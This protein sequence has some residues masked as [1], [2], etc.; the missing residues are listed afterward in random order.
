V[1]FRGK[2]FQA[3]RKLVDSTARYTLEEGVAM[4]PKVATAKFDE[5]VDLAV[6]LGVDPRQADQMVRGAVSLPHGVGKAVRVVV[7]AE[8]EAAKQAL[9]AGA[10]VVGG[11]ELI[12]KIANERWVDFDKAISVRSL[13]A[14]VGRLGAVLGPRGLMPNP[15]SGTVVGPEEIA[16][17]VREVKGGRV[18]FRVEKAGIIHAPVGKA[19]MSADQ[20]RENVA[21]FV[22]VLLRLK[23]ATSKG[24]YVRSATLSTTMGPGV[25]LDANELARIASETA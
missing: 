3:A 9:E 12:N 14:K 6:R 17:V 19:S 25:R 22:G 8:G 5:T 23:P 16:R 2:R 1:A 7:F 10:D 21:A 4:L 15:K 24:Q 13:M 20:I 18:D 11:D